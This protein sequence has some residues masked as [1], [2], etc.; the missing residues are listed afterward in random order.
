MQSEAAA[1]EFQPQPP[2]G[3]VAIKTLF[4]RSDRKGL[5]QLVIHV[6]L[7][8]A[9]GTGIYFSSGWLVL[10]AMILHGMVVAALF[11]PFHEGV[12]YTPFKSRRL[13]EVV[14]WISGTAIIW[15]STWYRCS[16]AHHHRYC[17]DAER[18]PE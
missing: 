7:L 15:N 2:M 4:E 18:D 16:H 14:A 13:N 6:C 11:A 9:T 17:Q 10:P 1:L 3:A 12:H 8:G 5:Q